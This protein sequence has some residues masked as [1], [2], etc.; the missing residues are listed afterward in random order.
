[1]R[2]T[3]E[4]IRVFRIRNLQS[5]ACLAC[6]RE[7]QSLSRC[8]RIQANTHL[9]VGFVD[10]KH[11]PCR[12]RLSPITPHSPSVRRPPSQNRF[13]VFLLSS[14]LSSSCPPILVCRRSGFRDGD[15]ETTSNVEQYPLSCP[16]NCWYRS[17]HHQ[18]CHCHARRNGLRPAHG[19][20]FSLF[21][22]HS[23]PDL[24]FM[25]GLG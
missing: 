1:L 8:P 21:E 22:R 12:S 25:L 16:P 6:V 13:Q 19:A 17:G 7:S 14:P 9:K 11:H 15:P 4:P 3:R 18:Q 10:R 20:R 23:K 2:H 24:S 5:R